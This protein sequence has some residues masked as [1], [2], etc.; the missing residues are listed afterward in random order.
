M[1]PGT[2]GRT[3]PGSSGSADP[4]LCFWRTSPVICDWDS[5]KSQASYGRWAIALR[6]DSL[7]RRKLAR[8]IA[9]S[10]SSR[11]P[12]AKAETGD[13]CY[14]R[15]D[16]RRPVLNLEG[17]AK[18]WATPN[19]H[20]GRRPGHEQDSTQGGN[21]KRDA[22]RWATHSSRDWKDTAGMA[23][24]GIN[25]D[26][27]MRK[28]ND[29]LGRQA[30]Q[31]TGPASKK[32]SGRRLNPAFVCWLMNFPEGWVDFAPLDSINY[33]RWAMQSSRVVRRWLTSH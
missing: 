24:T 10:G 15:G 4:Q 9:E 23:A 1:T 17:A 16:H 7:R 31:A 27:S 12:T 18:R 29:Q 21:L 14:S 6:R 13:Y 5:E 19:S 32:G 30:L 11:W 26:G 3:S 8:R 2:S 28:R 22:E 25:P 33:E 20:D